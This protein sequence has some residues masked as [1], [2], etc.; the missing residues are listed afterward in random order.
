MPVKFQD[1]TGSARERA[2][3]RF[4][5]C[6]EFWDEPTIDHIKDAAKEIFGTDIEPAYSGFGHQG[7]YFSFSGQRLEYVGNFYPSFKEQYGQDTEL[8]NIAKEWQRFQRRYFYQMSVNV[9]VTNHGGTDVHVT[10]DRKRFGWTTR[11]QDSEAAEVINSFC[12]WAFVLLEKEYE[13]QWSE[14]AMI[15]F[16]EGE[17][18]EEE[19]ED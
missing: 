4:A 12:H 15:E 18:F 1:L 8:L 9:R 3:Q 10:D 16:F 19:S 2:V 11:E 17:T 5:D 6:F 14:P 13:S 7:Q